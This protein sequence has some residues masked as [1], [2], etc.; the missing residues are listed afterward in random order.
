MGVGS[1]GLGGIKEPRGLRARLVGTHYSTIPNGSTTQLDWQI[2]QLSWLGS[3]KQAYFDGLEYCASSSEIGDTISFQVV[4]KDGLVYPAGTVLEEF[5]SDIYVMPDTL[6][7]TVLYKA[8]LPAGMYLRVV[9]K[10]TGST[11]VKIVCNIFRHLAEN[12]DV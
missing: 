2:P 12:E 3:D 11:D 8:K 7:R 5:A 6:N 4:D 1:K 10:S 9:Y